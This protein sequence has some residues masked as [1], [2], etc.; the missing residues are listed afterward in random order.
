MIAV[1]SAFGKWKRLPIDK[2]AKDESGVVSVMDK[3]IGQPTSD[4]PWKEMEK[5]I[6][7]YYGENEAVSYEGRMR[8]IDDNSDQK[9]L[10]EEMNY[11]FTVFNGMYHYRLGQL[12]CIAKKDFVL[13]IDHENKTIARSAVTPAK[14]TSLLDMHSLKEI[15]EKQ[16]GEVTIT[17]N[18]KE[19]ILTVNNIKDPVIQGYQVFYDPETY[20]IKKMV[21]G[22]VRLNPLGNPG[23]GTA[24]LP[25]F[26]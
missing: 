10:L 15:L 9:K 1:A 3:S 22:M 23:S 16:V 13:L 2:I 20:R 12:E 25:I 6:R 5:L 11:S 26:E 21:I 19:K 14:K 17:M 18:E 8:L 24:S 4:D 7:V